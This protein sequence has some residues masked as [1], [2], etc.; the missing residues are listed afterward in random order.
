[1]YKVVKSTIYVSELLPK[2]SL[3]F[4]FDI[5]LVFNT[6]LKNLSQLWQNRNSV[7]EIKNENKVKYFQLTFE[8]PVS[9]VESM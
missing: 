7:K 9:L 4:C 2:C 6:E 1:M 8:S 5:F 3:E